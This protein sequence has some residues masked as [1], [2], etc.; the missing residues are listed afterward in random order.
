M[1]SSYAAVTRKYHCT[2][3]GLSNLKKTAK[4]RAHS[5]ELRACF[6][7]VPTTRRSLKRVQFKEL[8]NRHGIVSFDG[9]LE[10]LQMA[11]QLF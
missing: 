11:T 4:L 2:P 1:D 3:L 10:Q 9:N 8:P 7:P 5:E 6:V